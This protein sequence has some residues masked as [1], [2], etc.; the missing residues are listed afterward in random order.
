[1]KIAAF[2]IVVWEDKVLLVNRRFPPQ[3]WAPPGGFIDLGESP[4]ETVKRETWE[5]TGII[6]DVF[7]KIHEFDFNESHLLVYAC[8]YISGELQCSYE[9]IEVGWF[10]IDDLPTSLSPAI[11]IFQKAIASFKS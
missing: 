8:Q 3:L 10:N 5:E 11:E 4:E 7:S 9:S 2:G 6:C 1:M